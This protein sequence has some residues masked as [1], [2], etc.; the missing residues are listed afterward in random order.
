[1]ILESYLIKISNLSFELLQEFFSCF[2]GKLLIAWKQSWLGLDRT[3]ICPTFSH[4]LTWPSSTFST[5]INFNFSLKSNSFQFL[6]QIS[7]NHRNKSELFLWIMNGCFLWYFIHRCSEDT[8]N[9][10]THY[11]GKK[12]LLLSSEV[13]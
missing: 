10:G 2:I 3:D 7:S 8:L 6:P 4:C 1:M 12:K 5:F 13:E 11:W 9:K